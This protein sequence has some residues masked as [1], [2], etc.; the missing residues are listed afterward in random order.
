[1]K[2]LFVCL[3]GLTF[4]LIT[5]CSMIN[6]GPDKPPIA[7]DPAY[8]N[9]Q[10]RLIPLKEMS[11][12][13]TEYPVAVLLQY[14]STNEIVFPNNF[15]LRI[16]IQQNDQWLEIKEQPTTRPKD[17]IILSRQALSRQIVMFSPELD[18]LTKTYHMR[19]YVFG[20]MKTQE[21]T[22][23]VAAFVNFVL[24]P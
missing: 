23:Q 5:S 24:T 22:K 13:K 16:F 21:G 20:D 3:L 12:F 7:F 19:V 8:L 2:R 6:S 15:N 11:A 4:F 14:T 10:I 18:D 17:P 9:Q 1:M